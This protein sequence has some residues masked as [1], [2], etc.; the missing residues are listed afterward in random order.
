MFMWQMAV[1]NEY[2][3]EELSFPCRK[4]FQ[5]PGD[6]I[7]TGS[8]LIPAANPPQTQRFIASESVDFATTSMP[9]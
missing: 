5:S 4:L 8:R 9:R 7:G 3:N 2:R 6:L 1:Q